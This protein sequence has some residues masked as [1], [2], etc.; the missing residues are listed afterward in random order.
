MNPN[1]K[2]H[3]TNG[4]FQQM[5]IICGDCQNLS[6]KIEVSDPMYDKIVWRK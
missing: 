5:Q 1:D 3:F 6:D 2:K 4:L